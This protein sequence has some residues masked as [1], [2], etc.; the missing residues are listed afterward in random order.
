MDMN[1]GPNRLPV[2]T[3]RSSGIQT[4]EASGASPPGVDRTSKRRFPKV[5]LQWSSK[6]VSGTTSGTGVSRPLTVPDHSLPERR[7]IWGPS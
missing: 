1:T 5:M 3:T 6:V 2:N 4:T 7:L